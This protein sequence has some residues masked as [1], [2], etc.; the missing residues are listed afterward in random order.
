MLFCVGI[1]M[2]QMT[3]SS[4]GGCGGPEM[5]CGPEMV[6]LMCDYGAAYVDGPEMVKL[7]CDCGA[8]FV[9]GLANG[10]GESLLMDLICWLLH[11]YLQP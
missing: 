1:F 3:F 6:K 9:D 10:D 11:L 4:A 5:F 8:A 2:F 7:L